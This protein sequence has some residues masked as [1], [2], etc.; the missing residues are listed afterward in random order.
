MTLS[1][2]LGGGVAGLTAAFEL[3]DRGHRVELLES[4]GWLGGRVFSFRDQGTGHLLD[5]GPHV[6]LGC[7]EHMRRLLR[8]I[9]T[10]GEFEVGP[11]LA[12]TYRLPGGRVHVLRLRSWST[13]LAMPMALWSLP[14]TIGERMRLLLGC[15]HLLRGAPGPWSLADWIARRR[16]HGGPQR[17]LWRPLSRSIMN[18]EPEE[19]GADLFLKT[20]REAFR[21]RAHRAAMWFPRRPW[22]EIVGEPAHSKLAAEGATVTPGANVTAL[23]MDGDRITGIHLGDGGH[24]AVDKGGLVVSALPWHSLSRLLPDGVI[25]PGRDLQGSPLISVYFDL[26]DPRGM[27]AEETLVYLV[28]GD[29]FHYL[30]RTPGHPGQR[31][32]LMAGGCTSLGG[33][34]VEDI[35]AI[36]RRQLASYYPDW[37]VDA[38]ARVRVA[39]EARATF[40]ARPEVQRPAPGPHADLPRN[41]ITCGD[42]TD[43]GLPST[44]EGAALSAHLALSATNSGANRPP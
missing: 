43:T 4:R 23:T 15:L 34:R 28:D 11:S 32:A 13:S 25:P 24:R 27:L 10:E 1:Y 30:Y 22:S 18:A 6:M 2:V 21:G 12:L 20:L 16:Q 33:H 39:K 3:L 26:D 29:P 35:E 17:F 19:V 8:R 14:M 37:P 41:L 42:W 9:G 38:P 36:A 5:N 44:L 40:L 7:Y 31:F